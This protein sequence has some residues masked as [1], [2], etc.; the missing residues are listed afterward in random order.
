MSDFLFS[1]GA[2]SAQA[3][4]AVQEFVKRSNATLN[5][6]QKVQFA[7]NAGAK[8][9]LENQQRL[10]SLTQQ[11]LATEEKIVAAQSRN[12]TSTIG[13]VSG[14]G[15]GSLPDISGIASRNAGAIGKQKDALD[16][17]NRIMGNTVFKFVEYELVMKAFNSA[18]GEVF[19]SLNEASNV[20][21][22][23]VLQRLYNAQINTNL[24]LKDS[25]IIAKQ[26]G[27][28]ITDVQQAIGLW[29][30]QTS[31]MHDATGKLV[32][33][34]T[35][36]A[37]AAKLAA[38]AE[39]FHRAS[40][41]ESLE[42]YQKSIS[43]WHELGLSLGQIP[44]LYD[45][46]AFAAT[47]I[48]PVLKAQ[49]GG[50]SKQEGIKDIFEGMAESG[51]TLRA[52]GMDDSLIIATVAKQIEN[53]GSTGA[54]V[55]NQISTM[56]GSLNQ[57]GNQLREWVKILGPD[58]FKDS[59]S[60]MD[61]AI[62][63][64]DQLKQAQADGALHVK[65]QTINTWRTFIETLSQVKELADQIRGHSS[66]TLDIIA[67]AQMNTYNGQVERLKASFQEL[68]LA[69]GT[70]LLPTMTHWISFLSGT[71]LPVLS[72]N[73]SAIAGMAQMGVELAG[74]YLLMLGITKVGTALG[75]FRTELLATSNAEVTAGIVAQQFRNAQ[76]DTVAGMDA[77]T[78]A[79]NQQKAALAQ[80]SDMQKVALWNA[81]GLAAQCKLLGIT[82]AELAEITATRL[83]SAFAA[84]GTALSG[85]AARAAAT[86]GPLAALYA[87]MSGLQNFDKTARISAAVDA[88]VHEQ[89][90]GAKGIFDTVGDMVKS[91]LL[92]PDGGTANS[93]AARIKAN[94]GAPARQLNDAQWTLFNNPKATNDQKTDA[95]EI[96][97]T[98]L[99][100]EY[101]KLHGSGD[102]KGYDKLDD[103]PKQLQAIMNR[104]MGGTPAG[105][106]MPGPAKKTGHSGQATEQQIAAEQT[107]KDKADAMA[108][109]S[110]WRDTANAAASYA[111]TLMDVGKAQG[112]TAD[113]VGR[114]AGHL[115]DQKTAIQ[116][117]ESAAKAEI[118]TLEAQQKHLE[119]LLKTHGAVVDAKGNVHGG[120]NSAAVY[121][122][123]KSW[124]MAEEAITKAQGALKG[125]EAQKARLA[126]DGSQMLGEAK[127]WAA[128][129]ASVPKTITGVVSS[130][131]DLLGDTIVGPGQSS[132][133]PLSSPD[134]LK[135]YLSNV[136]NSLSSA[137]TASGKEG[138]ANASLMSLK[139]L[140]K[141]VYDLYTQTKDPA[142]LRAFSEA[143]VDIR[144]AGGE[145]QK[146]LV[147]AQKATADFEK[148]LDNL[149]AK[150]ATTDAEGIG[151]LL[152]LSQGDI[153]AQKTLIDGYNSINDAFAQIN[154]WVTQEAGTYANL[155]AADKQRVQSAVAYLDIQQQLIPLLAQQQTIESS[156]AYQA[157]Q[158][159]LEKAGQTQIDETINRLM[160][161]QSNSKV[162]ESLY[163]AA[164]DGT[165]MSPSQ[166]LLKDYMT[167]TIGSWWKQTV[168]QM[169]Q[170]MF[171]DPASQARQLEATMLK[172]N[173]DGLTQIVQNEKTQV[174]D[175]LNHFEQLFAADVAKLVKAMNS[176]GSS[177]P[178]SPGGGGPS[179]IP[180]GW[181]S[182]PG[183]G[184][185]IGDPGPSPGG[186]SGD[187]RVRT[188]DRNALGT[189]GNPTFIAAHGDGPEGFLSG[190]TSQSNMANAVAQGVDQSATMQRVA[191][192]TGVTNDTTQ[193][194]ANNVTQ[195]IQGGAS[196][197]SSGGG[198]GILGALLGPL[199]QIPGL[200][201]Y[202]SSSSGSWIGG[203]ANAA[204]SGAGFGAA[205]GGAGS[206]N[207]TW[208]AVG[209]TL[210]YGLGTA[211][212]GPVIGQAA[213]MVGGILGGLFG[214]HDNPLDEPDVYDTENYGKFVANVNGAGG[215]F[216]GTFIAPDPQ[217][218]LADG[219]T[220]LDQLMIQW[221]QKNPTNPIAKQIIALGPRLD[222][223][224]EYQ[225]MFTLGSGKTISV[226]AYEQLVQQYLSAAGN[227]QNAPIVSVNSYGGG[228]ASGAYN[229]PG[230]DSATFMA[231]E[232]AWAQGV[233]KSS[234]YNSGGGPLMGGG[235]GADGI[236][237]GS[238]GFASGPN[239]FNNPNPTSTPGYGGSAMARAVGPGAS[240]TSL[241]LQFSTPVYL[242]GKLI[243]QIVN[244]YN[245]Q[246][247]TNN[248]MNANPIYADQ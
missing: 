96:I 234:G 20:Q 65:P 80:L 28:D 10:L 23:M 18:V 42:V 245:A 148:N 246:A 161:T 52:Q 32:D 233:N 98:L 130:T 165:W 215:T 247:R 244:A 169:T 242:D 39:K 184:I 64:V 24:A 146:G 230:M 180:N 4:A 117:G 135:A 229:T 79:M 40:G 86:L 91:P 155:T 149:I 220:P 83:P 212:G 193:D 166:T 22:E 121:A 59:E 168:Q 217:Y 55:G 90:G 231:E 211:F 144:K 34:Q 134:A 177:N 78:A 226:T 62:A 103:I 205:F 124:R 188:K 14:G 209:G 5:N 199:M 248:G 201:K 147:E 46:I 195:L 176:G 167:N 150:T 191:D 163:Q 156:I 15:G 45:Q 102:V 93:L 12:R 95:G 159:T 224:S 118:T 110:K 122:E 109:I 100:D 31:Q 44:H 81:E 127:A 92:V 174:V 115:R 241:Q 112:F 223:A 189:E 7:S 9:A 3:D 126:F 114:L 192:N 213:G 70:Q 203:L 186:P 218:D 11:R 97:K 196:Q 54:K 30:K 175:G 88:G 206:T 136:N 94:G 37:A 58:A 77:A 172:Q 178:N 198:A 197:S 104:A 170:T 139:D 236:L 152:G 1:I 119:A 108:E 74:T 61:A 63:K 116:N 50:T 214:H 41:I 66:G 145:A 171:G 113:M 99:T 87:I 208:G 243:T 133:N 27:S 137:A 143:L 131:K 138:A 185:G 240:L 219:G 53:L 29:T 17:L 129:S 36:L 68:N 105:M 140:T 128:I 123:A 183:G 111:K 75:G 225:G 157:M 33:S 82:E 151:K 19:N 6:I 21:M 73:S 69:L 204:G 202:L 179:E 56:F 43:I 38:D 72:K 101:N 107:N 106:T 194:A 8:Q 120:D 89:E 76:L 141:A 232:T 173:R 51:A 67:S 60:F 210:G 164:K 57:G 35:A 16:F 221:A 142:E 132:A 216:N 154:Q 239:I 227:Q 25:I 207:T 48:S 228:G 153:D 84:A 158:T 125:Y 47:K 200:S 49:P 162:R 13:A 71:M 235:G 26:W 85:F 237:G 238:S 190:P 160:G 2:D 187:S 222:I 181:Y 182:T